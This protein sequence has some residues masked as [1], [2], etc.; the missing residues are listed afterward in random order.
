MSWNM[1]SLLARTRGVLRRRARGR[2]FGVDLLRLKNFSLPARMRVGERWADLA[3][4]GSPGVLV[5]FVDVILE[6]CYGLR[7]LNPGAI[8]TVVDIG[9]NIGLFALSARKAFPAAAIHCYEP[10]PAVFS[11]LRRNVEGFNI[12]THPEAVGADDGWV[13][14]SPRNLDSV[15][16]RTV[17]SD[18]G[19]IPQVSIGRVA[20]RA[21]AAIDL[22]KLDCEGAEWGILASP[23]AALDR[24]RHLAMEYHAVDGRPIHSDIVALVERRGFRVDVQ[25]VAHEQ[26]GIVLA[27]RC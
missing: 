1:S 6:D 26:Y 3:S 2:E 22:L 18:E 14:L 24:V 23:C 7:S 12:Q 21:G 4:D 20:T 25:H 27:T 8:S 16:M 13:M 19:E 17:P 11:L 15:Q 5:S 10:N 9:A